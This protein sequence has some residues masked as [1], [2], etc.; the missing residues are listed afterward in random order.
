MKTSF[1]K[2]KFINLYCYIYTFRKKK[3]ILK[4]V[5]N[6]YHKINSIR[7]EIT[8]FIAKNKQILKNLKIFLFL[9]L[10]KIENVFVV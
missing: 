10:L 5:I 6:S 9:L 7:I 1:H 8:Y 3:T 2:N 4:S